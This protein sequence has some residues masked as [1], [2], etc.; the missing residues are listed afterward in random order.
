MFIYI[1]FKIADSVKI[2]SMFVE[3]KNAKSGNIIKN[4]VTKNFHH[5]ILYIIKFL[6]LFFMYFIFFYTSILRKIHI[7]V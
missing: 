3:S 4:V 7:F 1:L 2:K 5:N 6:D